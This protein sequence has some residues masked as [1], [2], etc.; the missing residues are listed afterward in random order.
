MKNLFVASIVFLVLCNGKAEAFQVGTGQPYST[1]S[2]ALQIAQSGDSI[3]VHEGLY[4]EGNIVVAKSISL[5]GLNWPVLDGQLKYEVVSI[6]ASHVLFTGFKVQHSGHASL[7][8]P[9]GIKVYDSQ[10]VNIIGN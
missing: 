9:G 10:Y 2:S 8:D 1:I 4:K 5:I 3:L 6:K 7:E